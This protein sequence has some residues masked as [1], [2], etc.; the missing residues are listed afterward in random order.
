MRGTDG[1]LTMGTFVVSKEDGERG[2]CDRSKDVPFL[3][4]VSSTLHLTMG[5]SEDLGT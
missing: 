4:I 2:R 1:R 3:D 5:Q